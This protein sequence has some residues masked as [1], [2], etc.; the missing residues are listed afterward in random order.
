MNSFHLVRKS[1]RCGFFILTSASSVISMICGSVAAQGLPD[2]YVAAQKQIRLGKAA[3]AAH[4]LRRLLGVTDAQVGT[5][6][7]QHEAAIEQEFA[8]HGDGMDQD[9]LARILAGTFRDDAGETKSLEE[10][11]AHPSARMA[12]L[13]R[14]HIL[15]L[16]LYTTCSFSKIND[17]LRKDPPDRPHPFAATTFFISEG[18]KMLRAVEAQLPD[19]YTERIYWR[20]MKDLGI[21]G[22]FMTKGGTDF[23]CV[24]TTAH[25]AI[26]VHNFASSALPLVFKVVTKN[27]LSRGADISF[28]SVYPTEQEALYP[29]LTYLRCLEMKM[30]TLSGVQLL[31]ATV[32]PMMA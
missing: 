27:C 4:G 23:A 29:P 18:I 3:D 10:L 32:E 5:Y 14:H 20:G 1:C 13:G 31:V 24:S 17:P 11:L 26:A 8:E 2:K 30:E 6:L 19:A 7:Q 28:L 25:Q 22:E 21:T 16:R 15:A 12:K 9:N